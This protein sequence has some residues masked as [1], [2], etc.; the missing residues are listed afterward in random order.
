MYVEKPKARIR[1]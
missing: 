1:S